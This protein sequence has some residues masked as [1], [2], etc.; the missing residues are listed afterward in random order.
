MLQGREFDDHDASGTPKVAIVNKALA[1]RFRPAEAALGR[2]L[3]VG[4]THFQIVGACCT[5][6]KNSF[7][8]LRERRRL[9]RKVN[10]SR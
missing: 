8:R 1:R 3:I 5:S 7:P 9:N 6:R 2:V 10:S 4:G